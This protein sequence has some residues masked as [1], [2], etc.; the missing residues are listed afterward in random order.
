[1]IWFSGDSEFNEVRL[2]RYAAPDQPLVIY[3]SGLDKRAVNAAAK[4]VSL[5]F[6]KVYYFQN[7]LKKWKAAGYPVDQGDSWKRS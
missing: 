3:S 2:A 5:G 4:A 6:K 7:G 1:M